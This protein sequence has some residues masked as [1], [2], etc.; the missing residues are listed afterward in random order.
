MTG[1][2]LWYIAQAHG[3]K[4]LAGDGKFTRNCHGWLEQKTGTKKALT[5]AKPVTKP[6]RTAKVDPL[7]PLPASGNSK[8][9]TGNSGTAR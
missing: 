2:E 4:H 8:K 3:N 5:A 1:K 7:A 9:T 6:I